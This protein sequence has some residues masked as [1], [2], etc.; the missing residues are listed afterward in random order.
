VKLWFVP[1]LVI[2]AVAFVVI[3][4]ISLPSRW[5]FFVLALSIVVG[6]GA[7]PVVFAVYTRHREARTQFGK[8]EADETR[9]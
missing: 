7:A 6:L 8:A 2:A 1:I 9:P 3:M 4:A 5:M